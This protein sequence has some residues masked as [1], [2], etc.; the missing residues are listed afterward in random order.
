[1][2]FFSNQKSPLPLAITAIFAPDYNWPL[3]E[4]QARISKSEAPNESEYQD[5]Q[6]QDTPGVSPAEP[7]Q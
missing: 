3:K 1:M 5:A 4:R 2:W 7:R 6:F